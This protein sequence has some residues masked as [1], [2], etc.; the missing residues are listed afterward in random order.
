MFRWVVYW[1]Q[2]IREIKTAQKV[3]R[4]KSITIVYKEA[5]LRLDDEIITTVA[6]YFRKLKLD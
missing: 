2:K 3:L 6:K 1:G 4:T 5:E